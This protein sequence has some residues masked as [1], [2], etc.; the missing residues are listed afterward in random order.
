M[1]I[2]EIRIKLVEENSEHLMAFCSVT[3]D[4]DFVIRDLKVVRRANG[5][6]IS[7]PSRKLTDRCRRCGSR[8]HLRA[9]FCNCCGG[10]L[11][12]NRA[13]LDDNGRPKLNAD[14]CHPINSACRET[15]Q[16]AIIGAYH[17][18]C[19]LSKQSGYTCIYGIYDD[20]EVEANG[21]V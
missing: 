11:N 13:P 6:F 19:E 3:F 8:N 15:M 17:N 7:M 20:V 4:N 16:A 21:V 12:E 9:R 5:L 10:R 18:E 2:T 1:V 14:I